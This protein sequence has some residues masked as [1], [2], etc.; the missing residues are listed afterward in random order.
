M[1]HNLTVL[2]L[3]LLP[4]RQMML[5]SSTQSP[6]ASITPLDQ[7][8][9]PTVWCPGQWRARH[10]RPCQV[11]RRERLWCWARASLVDAI[12]Q[13]GQGYKTKCLAWGT[14]QPRQKTTRQ[15]HPQ[16]KK[17]TQVHAPGEHRRVGSRVA[18]FRGYCTETL[19]YPHFSCQA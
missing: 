8:R 18:F 7:K 4:K 10:G 17:E 13:D 9:T 15:L 3:V 16:C 6:W 11:P 2:M 1:I 12:A 14:L 5:V 19:G